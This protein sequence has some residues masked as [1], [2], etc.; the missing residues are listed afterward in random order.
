MRHDDD[1]IDDEI[2]EYALAIERIAM[3]AIAALQSLAKQKEREQER[4]SEN[5]C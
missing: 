4:R 2:R 3:T 1:R 5:R